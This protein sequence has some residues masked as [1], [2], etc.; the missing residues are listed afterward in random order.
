MT[1]AREDDELEEAHKVVP[2]LTNPSS[3]SNHIP[4]L[5]FWWKIIHQLDCSCDLLFHFG[6]N[7]AECV[8]QRVPLLLM[9]ILMMMTMMTLCLWYNECLCCG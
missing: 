6:Q 1:L 7:Y 2:T 8:V 3:K 9:M 5:P 4:N